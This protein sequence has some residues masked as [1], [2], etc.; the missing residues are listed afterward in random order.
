[1]V[2]ELDTVTKAIMRKVAFIPK[3]FYIFDVVSN[4][5]DPDSNMLLFSGDVGGFIN[6]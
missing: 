6:E 2:N 3:D 4:L 5:R 1:M